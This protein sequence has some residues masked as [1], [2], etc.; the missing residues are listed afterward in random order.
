[1]ATLRE[2][3]RQ[4]KGQLKSLMLG[5]RKLDAAQESFE[6]EVK[7]IV[8]RKQAVPEVADAQRLVVLLRAVSAAL[9]AL[10]TILESLSVSWSSQ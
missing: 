5:S 2:I 9:D 8:V 4:K 7:R 1:M 3:S 6:R 10:A